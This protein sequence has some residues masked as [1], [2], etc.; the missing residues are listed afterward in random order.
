MSVTE[1]ISK[2]IRKSLTLKDDGNKITPYSFE[3]IGFTV[4][5]MNTARLYDELAWTWEILVSEEE[6]RPEVEFVKKMIKKYKKTPGNELLDVGCGAGHHDLF[7]K[8][9][10]EVVGIDGSEKML[11]LAKRRNPELVYHLRD[12][13]TFQL[14]RQFDVV[15]AMDMIMYNLTYPDLEKTLTNLSNH[16]KASGVMVFFVENL[17]EKF[18][19]NKTRSKKHKKG[20]IEI[21]LIENDYDINPDDTEFECHLIFLIRKEERL[22]IEVDKHRMGLFDLDKML[23]ILD[24]LNFKTHLYELD[25]SGR[26][27]QKEGPLFVCEKLS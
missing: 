21:V 10:F 9:D 20:N 22:Q 15:M 4:K 26:K 24:D 14:N 6:Y 27:Y 8:D 2:N 16:L 25:F 1:N 5:Q 12:M 3:E 19:Q 18:E 23:Q 11:E 7:L 17:K 13:R